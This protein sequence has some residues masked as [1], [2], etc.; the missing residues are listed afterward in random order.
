MITI[1]H[2]QYLALIFAVFWGYK[3]AIVKSTKLDRNIQFADKSSPIAMCDKFSPPASYGMAELSSPVKAGGVSIGKRRFKATS[4]N[5]E[6][7]D[8]I[9]IQ[10]SHGWNERGGYTEQVQNNMEWNFEDQIKFQRLNLS[11]KRSMTRPIP[12]NTDTLHWP[13]SK[14]S[15]R[16]WRKAIRKSRIACGFGATPYYDSGSVLV[17]THDKKWYA[18]H[19]FSSYEMEVTADGRA[20]YDTKSKG[21][22]VSK[23]YR[24]INN[25]RGAW[26]TGQ[27]TVVDVIEL[28]A[29]VRKHGG[30]LTTMAPRGNG[31]GINGF[32]SNRTARATSKFVKD[33]TEGIFHSV[34]NAKSATTVFKEATDWIE[35]NK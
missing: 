25:L 33:V 16:A 24:K 20:L 14:A 17:R 5:A 12:W 28:S 21:P 6:V 31:H 29:I 7:L 4:F 15:E 11:S 22:K 32:N 35:E 19:T 18:A 27:G 10:N 9:V 8:I 3:T 34:K 23:A 13:T 2:L 26:G 30:Y 1:R